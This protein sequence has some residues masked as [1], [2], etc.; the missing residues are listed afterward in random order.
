MD[1]ESV[2]PSMLLPSTNA[3]ASS[4][5]PGSLEAA[6]RATVLEDVGG[7]AQLLLLSFLLLLPLLPE[8]SHRRKASM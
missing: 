6:Q 8:T 5:R 1:D 3:A 4:T 2:R 7:W